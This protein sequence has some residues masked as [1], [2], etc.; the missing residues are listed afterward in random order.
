MKK[1]SYLFG[2]DK[3]HQEATTKRPYK[4]DPAIQ[5]MPRYQEPFYRN[6]DLYDTEGVDGPPKHGPGKGYHSMHNYKSVSDFLKH[7]RKLKNKYKAKDLYK[8]DSGELV[9]KASEFLFKSLIKNAI[10]YPS[11]DIV[12]PILP[13]WGT[14][15][16][17]VPTAGFGDYSWSKSDFEGKL[18]NELN[19]GRDYTNDVKPNSI[20]MAKIKSDLLKLIS[21]LIDNYFDQMLSGKEN[22]LYGLP[23]GISP[24]SD[25]DQ[26]NDQQNNYV[27]TNSTN[28]TY[29]NVAY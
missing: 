12:S 5:V 26:P 22:S 18:P 27:T 21:N 2:G 19:F 17:S 3:A 8:L 13:Q 20:N 23:D 9:R 4:A 11:D 10:D 25:L 29:K 7:R 28:T 1:N 6:Y 15:Q 14:Y 16:D 24:T